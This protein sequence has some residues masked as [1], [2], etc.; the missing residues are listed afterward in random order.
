MLTFICIIHNRLNEEGR[1]RQNANR[2]FDSQNNDRG[3]HNV[4]SL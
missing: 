1:E 2:M 3:G 4:G